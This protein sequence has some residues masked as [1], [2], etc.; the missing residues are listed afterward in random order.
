M[1]KQNC[2]KVYYNFLNFFREKD[3]LD[4]EIMEKSRIVSERFF[5]GVGKPNSENIL[6]GY[7]NIFSDVNFSALGSVTARKLAEKVNLVKN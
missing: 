7:V 6:K 4:D 2:N 3:T 5:P 1:V